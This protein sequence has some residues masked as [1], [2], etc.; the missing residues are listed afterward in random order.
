MAN[1]IIATV[2]GLLLLLCSFP[3]FGFPSQEQYE[4][5]VEC[6]WGLPSGSYPDICSRRGACRDGASCCYSAYITTD[7]FPTKSIP[8]AYFGGVV[9]SSPLSSASQV[10]FSDEIALSAAND[11]DP[12]LPMA[13]P[14]SPQQA[15]QQAQIPTSGDAVAAIEATPVIGLNAEGFA[16]ERLRVVENALAENQVLGFLPFPDHF[17]VEGETLYASGWSATKGFEL[18]EVRDVGGIKVHDFNPAGDSHAGMPHFDQRT[19]RAFD[20]RLYFYAMT[21][22]GNAELSALKGGSAIKVLNSDP[23]SSDIPQ[24]YENGSSNLVYQDFHIDSFEVLRNRL[25]TA[26]SKR[27]VFSADEGFGLNDLRVFDI[28]PLRISGGKQPTVEIVDVTEAG[29]SFPSNWVEFNGAVYMIAKTEGGYAFCG[30][31]RNYQLLRLND[32]G[33]SEVVEINPD[34]WAFY[35]S[36]EYP[37]M[38]VVGDDL[39]LMANI[40]PEGGD[41]HE[42]VRVTPSHEVSVVPINPDGGA[43][44]SVDEIRFSFHAPAVPANLRKRGDDLY[45]FGANIAG[46]CASD[47]PLP[48]EKEIVKISAGGAVTVIDP[49]PD[50]GSTFPSWD[51]GFFPPLF[52]VSDF[53]GDSYFGCAFC[54]VRELVRLNADD[55]LDFFPQWPV[56]I[57]KVDGE[58][59]VGI[60]R[61]DAFYMSAFLLEFDPEFREVPYLL[62]ADNG[63]AIS[64]LAKPDFNVAFPR[65]LTVVDDVVV[66]SAL[67]FEGTEFNFDQTRGFEF[68]L[69]HPDDSLGFLDASPG[70]DSEGF[71]LSTFPEGLRNVGGAMTFTSYTDPSFQSDFH[72]LFRLQHNGKG[73]G[74][75][76]AQQQMATGAQAR[77][78][79]RPPSTS[80][81]PLPLNMGIDETNI[82]TA[83]MSWMMD[84]EKLPND[85]PAF[86]HRNR[87]ALLATNPQ[88]RAEAMQSAQA[89]EVMAERVKQIA[90][91][92]KVKPGA[93][94]SCPKP[95]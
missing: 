48:Y 63:G 70:T 32:D 46:T 17:A 90:A 6:C 16:V 82:E 84:Q 50:G 9:S 64:E 87:A 2:G 10:M 78:S 42:L 43:F 18:I 56:D 55:S 41:R 57:I 4:E 5:F 7:A 28:E 61:G 52:I 72:E 77:T 81:L 1:R 23:S 19:I 88:Y 83:M 80:V 8:C 38:Q 91:A 30:N 53:N 85:S 75:T 69:I 51:P 25:H 49:T 93:I 94:E 74:K 45:I 76:K 3:S 15:A 39:Y 54:N 13:C 36:V 79:L 67:I 59:G 73:E 27:V 58:F 12:S 92:R 21:A 31:G 33:T 89:A 60:Q 47:C 71:P 29:Q 95:Q 37:P 34:F 68:L 40:G 22:D 35:P 26:G 24:V 86:S 44:P 66:A 62:K 20:D 11:V 65:E 14:L